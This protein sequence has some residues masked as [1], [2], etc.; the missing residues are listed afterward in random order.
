MYYIHYSKREKREMRKWYLHSRAHYVSPLSPSSHAAGLATAAAPPF[1]SRTLPLSHA[2]MLASL[3]LFHLPCRAHLKHIMIFN[4][5]NNNYFF[6]DAARSSVAVL[7]PCRRFVLRL[8]VSRVAVPALSTSTAFQ[9]AGTLL[10]GRISSA[11]SI[12]SWEKHKHKHTQT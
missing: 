9:T 10:S 11:K 1:L 5:L 8:T 7:P 12:N 4:K 3:V 2:L 6:R